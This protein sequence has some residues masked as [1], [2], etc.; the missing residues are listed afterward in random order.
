[1]SEGPSSSTKDSHFRLCKKVAQLTK[2]IVQ[3]NTVNE[4]YAADK[5]S[6]IEI[7][8]VDKRRVRD[9]HA[10]EIKAITTDADSRIELL[11]NE[12]KLKEGDFEKF[13]SACKVKEEAVQKQLV[14]A[15]NEAIA[16]IEKL[17]EIHDREKTSHAQT[18]RDISQSLEEQS[19]QHQENLVYLRDELAEKHKK[20][21]DDLIK[22][23]LD[24]HAEEIKVLKSQHE[25]SIL[26]V[27]AAASKQETSAV[28][29]AVATTRRE[30]DAKISQQL[31]LHE[32][33]CEAI[34]AE[35]EERAG[36]EVKSLHEEL[37]NAN[38][39]R[40]EEI[41]SL[42]ADLH[43]CV[44]NEQK[45]QT[46]VKRLQTSLDCISLSNQKIITE[47]QN[48]NADLVDEVSEARHASDEG[49]ARID[50]L[51]AEVRL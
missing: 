33:K 24:N 48:H 22:K 12:L 13:G 25:Q 41:A 19:R 28:E 44:G 35:M 38:H 10:E 50:S 26:R 43:V 11:Q 49:Q 29:D 42:R 39:D 17:E 3:L 32:N 21:A 46:E 20:N 9:A 47:L 15:Q 45:L 34:K 18:V 23:S 7:Y 31:S 8:E 16:R 14:T 4:N 40:A 30:Y 6:L 37:E 36:R 27:N 5:K 1:M 2:V 51:E